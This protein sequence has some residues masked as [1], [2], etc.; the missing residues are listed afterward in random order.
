MERLW[1]GWD[2]SGVGL[3]TNKSQCHLYRVVNNE[4]D[5]NL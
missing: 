5:L 4:Y 1:E 3:C 2:N